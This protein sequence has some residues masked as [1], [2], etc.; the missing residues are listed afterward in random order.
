MWHK[1]KKALHS[2]AKRSSNLTTLII[3]Q[4]EEVGND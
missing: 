2:G 4:K 1:A 3:P